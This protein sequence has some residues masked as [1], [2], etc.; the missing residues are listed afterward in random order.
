MEEAYSMDDPAKMRAHVLET[1]SLC[2]AT[3]DAHLEWFAKLLEGHIEGIASH[4]TFGISSGK[5]EGTNNLIKTLRRQGYGYPDDEY[6]FLKIFDATRRKL[7][8]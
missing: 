8:Y 3:G 2:R 4:A 1:A 6:F 5:V 7:T